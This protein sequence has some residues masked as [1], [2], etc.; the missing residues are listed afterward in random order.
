MDVSIDWV[1]ALAGRAMVAGTP[2][3]LGTLGE[4][5]TERAG[6]LNLGVEGIMAVGAVTGFGVAITS[7][8][9]WAGAL[10]AVIVGML[11]GL[12]HALVTVTLRANQVVAGLALTMLGLG[13]SSLIG[14]PFVGRPLPNPL[15]ESAIPLLSQLPVVGTSLFS[16]DPLFYLGLLLSI[17]LWF[18]LFRTRWGIVIRSCGESPLAAATCGVNVQAVRT[19]CLMA[20]CGLC[21]L[22]GAYLSLVYNPSWVEGMTAGRGWIV[23][24]LTIFSFWNPLRAVIGAYA[25]GAIYVV[26]YS[27]QSWNISPNLLMTLPYVL[28]LLA[29]TLLSSRAHRHLAAPA[30]LG[31]PFHPGE[32]S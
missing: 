10:A 16:R 23:I 22:A 6:I 13:L 32:K 3:L 9:P 12:V 5:L 2:L 30:A 27:L 20:G 19:L 17:G 26:Q 15:G 14:K 31:T 11:L 8:S 29:L 24:A 25:F 28:T 1:T 4:V 18:I 21:G 7:G